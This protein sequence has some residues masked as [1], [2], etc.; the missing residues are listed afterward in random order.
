VLCGTNEDIDHLLFTCPLANFAWSL[1]SEALG[2]Q[3]IPR[4]MEDL[5]NNWIPRKFGVGIKLGLACF[6]SVSWA[7]WH[8]RNKICIQHVCPNN[9][10]DVV[11]LALSFIQKWRI[12][13]RSLERAMVEPTVKKGQEH[14]RGFILPSNNHAHRK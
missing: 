6:A 13:M 9:S 3:G 8:T 4:S 12:L 10:L 7:V 11:Q 5:M 1:A 14:A 2:W